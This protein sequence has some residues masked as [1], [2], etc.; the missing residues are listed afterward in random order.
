MYKNCSE[1]PIYN[2]FEVIKT[3]DFKL[4][5][6]DGDDPADFEEEHLAQ[7]LI[8]IMNEY[9]GLTDNRKLMQ[10]YRSR[11]DIDYL[12]ARY[13]M[14]KELIS[15]YNEFEAIEIF[16]A[17]ADWNWKV[18]PEDK[19]NPQ[20]D[21]IIKNLVGIKNQINIKKANFK[22]R[23]GKKKDDAPPTFDLE[24]SIINLEIGI[25]LS[26]KIN[27]YKD[28]IKRYVFWTKALDQKNKT[29]KRNG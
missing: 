16:M 24:E 7:T 8:D 5:L 15:M 22:N 13:H 3:R 2:F 29:I 11:L 23:F 18:N 10:E 14:T 19:I 17:L 4:L 28:S 20:L 12:E 1:I 21:R 26:Y 6:E 27:I 9:N 25:P